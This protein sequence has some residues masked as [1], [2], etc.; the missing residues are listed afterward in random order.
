MS[1][2]K[3]RL[4]SQIGAGSLV[5]SV[6]ALPAFM[7][8]WAGSSGSLGDLSEIEM[9]GAG[10]SVSAAS[11]VLAGV[12]M[13]KALDIAARDPTV[14]RLDPW[15]AL[16]VGVTVLSV[17]VTLVPVVGLLSLLPDEDTALRSRTHSLAAIWICGSIVA[18]YL[19]YRVAR[20][21]LVR[22]S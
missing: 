16:I 15:A 4:V 5:F 18:G 12:L 1:A 13:G 2:S 22:R 6:L 14:G 7:I 10:L 9:L 11:G 21:V 3:G 19:S 17:S 20:W 8:W